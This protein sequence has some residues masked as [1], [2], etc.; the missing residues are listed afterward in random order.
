MFYA[1]GRCRVSCSYRLVRHTRSCALSINIRLIVPLGFR[2]DDC[3][4]E[5][6]EPLIDLGPGIP[7]GLA[8]V[9]TAWSEERLLAY[10]YAFEQATHVRLKRRAYAEAVPK[11]QLVD[12]INVA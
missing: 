4:S 1:G 9:G 7:F 12:V 11:S 2:P 6:A 3:I 8:F 5:T 10:A